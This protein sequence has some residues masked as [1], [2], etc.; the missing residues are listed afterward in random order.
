ML[1]RMEREIPRPFEGELVRLRAPERADAERLNALFEDVDVRAGLT[2]IWPQPLSGITDFLTEARA[3]PT[4]ETF[5]VETLAEHE[6]IGLCS[7]E[8]V[9]PRTRSAELGIWIGAR[10]WD[11]G[12]GTDA[13]RTLSRWGFAFANLHRIGLHV[14]ATNPRA[15]RAYEKVGFRLEGTLREAEFRDGRHVD[16]LVM[17]LLASE[18]R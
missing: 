15:R 7:L 5:A 9:D 18:L 4:S 10:F 13:T 12:Y 11:R 1:R 16:V 17:G 2:M 8:N 3:D 14:L 6:A